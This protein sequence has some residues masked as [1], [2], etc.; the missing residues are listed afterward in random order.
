MLV[1]AALVLAVPITIMILWSRTAP[2]SRAS[3]G[4]RDDLRTLRLRDTRSTPEAAQPGPVAS[5]PARVP[6]AA[7]ETPLAPGAALALR[8]P[9]APD[10]PLA[11]LAPRAPVAPLAPRAPRAPEAPLASEAPRAPELSRAPEPESLET[12]IGSR[13]LLY[14]G[15]IAIVVGVSWLRSSRST[16]VGQPDGAA[17]RWSAR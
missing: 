9:E 3:T 14:I 5:A 16:R 4:W 12:M 2:F 6:E 8:A 11:P 15:V 13:W 17:G 7:P 10:A 1:G